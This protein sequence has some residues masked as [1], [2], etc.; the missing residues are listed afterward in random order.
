MRSART[1][2]RLRAATLALTSLLSLVGGGLTPVAAANPSI[3]GSSTGPGGLIWVPNYGARSVMAVDPDTFEVTTEVKNVG[4]HPLVIKTNP[5]AS[6]MFVGN[7]GPED[8]SVTVI[9]TATKRIV[10]KIPLLGAAYAV[11]QMSHDGKHLYVP[12]STSLVQVIDTTTLEVVRTIPILLPPGIAHLEVSHDEKTLFIYSSSATVTRYDA[13]TGRAT[14]PPLFLNGFAPGWGTTSADGS[15]LYAVNFWDGITWIDPVD[16]KIVRTAHL[17]PWNANPISAT[18]TPDGTELWV[19]NYSSNDV[20]ILDAHTG[21]EKRRFST[22]GAAVYVD[23][24]DDG[25]KAYL[26]EVADGAPLPYISPLVA[27]GLYRA[28]D[29]AWFAPM[30]NLDTRLVEYDTANLKR[31]RQLQVKGAFVAGVYPS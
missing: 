19:C 14:A 20:R 6:K 23:F 2:T 13:R 7:F 24:T 4:S 25:S 21:A 17:A 22:N 28:K 16:W 26:T 5:D 10:K 8:W 3:A 29:E 12:T 1:R 11:I 27:N 18:L 30:L 15:M 9:D 31:G